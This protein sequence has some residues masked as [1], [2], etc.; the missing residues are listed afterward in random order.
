MRAALAAGAAVCIRRP[1]VVQDSVRDGRLRLVDVVD[2]DWLQ[3]RDEADEGGEGGVLQ[4]SPHGRASVLAGHDGISPRFLRE[5]H[6]EQLR[7]H[8]RD[9]PGGDSEPQRVPHRGAAAE[10]RQ[11]LLRRVGGSVL[12]HLHLLLGGRAGEARHLAVLLQSRC[13]AQHT[14]GSA[15]C[16]SLAVS[17]GG[18]VRA[19]AVQ[20]RVRGGG[21]RRAEDAVRAGGAYGADEERAAP[22]H[23]EQQRTASRHHARGLGGGEGRSAD[24]AV[25]AAAAVRAGDGSSAG[26]SRS[27][28][29]YGTRAGGGR[30]AGRAERGAVRVA[31][32]PDRQP[33]AG[34]AVQHRAVVLSPVP[35]V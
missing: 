32:L 18:A 8:R 7:L 17:S 5:P 10:R 12:P 29:C 23:Q 15:G 3:A 20:G 31:G 19:A 25:L 14:A 27:R 22:L 28:V 24:A 35:S 33:A 2:S 21:A 6:R 34:R 9:A 30:A 26:R 16:Q 1:A 11:D 4:E 13:A